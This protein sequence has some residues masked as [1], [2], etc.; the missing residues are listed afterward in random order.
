MASTA[1]AVYL[2]AKHHVDPVKKSILALENWF[3]TDIDNLYEKI[4][5]DYLEN[6]ALFKGQSTP[7]IM[8]KCTEI[9]GTVSQNTFNILLGALRKK[10]EADQSI[11]VDQHVQIRKRL[12]RY[13]PT[14]ELNL[15]IL[16]VIR[17]V[18]EE[19]YK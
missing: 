13:K 18:E 6:R 14:T 8:Q 1:E 5:Y 19:M 4:L 2:Y 3:S 12:D 16:S 11:T 7:D 9:A 15:D 17:T 10:L